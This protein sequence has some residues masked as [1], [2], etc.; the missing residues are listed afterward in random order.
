MSSPS[1]QAPFFR[2][3]L[4]VANRLAKVF[5]PPGFEELANGPGLNSPKDKLDAL[6]SKLLPRQVVLRAWS[7][8]ILERYTAADES[9]ELILKDALAWLPRAYESHCLQDPEDLFARICVFGAVRRLW[10]STTILDESSGLMGVLSPVVKLHHFPDHLLT[11]PVDLM[12]WI[13]SL[14]ATLVRL[15]PK[16]VVHAVLSLPFTKPDWDDE[17]QLLESMM[18]ARIRTDTFHGLHM[19]A[20]L[21][22]MA[23]RS[24]DSESNSAYEEKLTWMLRVMHDGLNSSYTLPSSVIAMLQQLIGDIESLENANLSSHCA[25]MAPF[26]TNKAAKTGPP[27]AIFPDVVPPFIASFLTD[28]TKDRV[29]FSNAQE[30]KFVNNIVEQ[31]MVLASLE[32]IWVQLDSDTDRLV[33]PTQITVQEQAL[34]ET[35]ISCAPGV[36]DLSYNCI[37]WSGIERDAN[38]ATATYAPALTLFFPLIQRFSLG[39]V[40]D[41]T[42]LP[43]ASHTLHTIG[44]ARREE[45]MM[46]KAFY[47]NICTAEQT[48]R[49]Y[50]F[51]EHEI[52][53]VVEM[54]TNATGLTPFKE[55]QFVKY[56]VAKRLQITRHRILE[57]LVGNLDHPWIDHSAELIRVLRKL[58]QEREPQT[59]FDVERLYHSCR[60][61]V[62]VTKETLHHL[63]LIWHNSQ[64]EGVR[65]KVLALVDRL[66]DRSIMREGDPNFTTLYR[67]LRHLE[68][69]VSPYK[70]AESLK[71]ILVLLQRAKAIQLDPLTPQTQVQASFD[72]LG[73]YTRFCS[74][75]A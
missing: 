1:P 12:P 50:P 58:T 52:Y 65:M 73:E 39:R 21:L 42:S 45:T 22:T 19:H 31:D 25:Q 8:L 26:I 40:V 56:T 62:E 3:L 63:R 14:D 64:S 18:S 53:R 15:A 67:W 32:G 44:T 60:Q 34:D 29:N 74:Y 35:L 36:F 75:Y 37:T 72:H 23:L 2:E 57:H 66:L 10:K 55:A 13:H 48:F 4:A 28:T 43:H 49:F 70:S 46:I 69:T 51:Y 6:M 7:K 20:Q 71:I 41:A 59:L 61:E 68:E 33:M 27:M 30:L 24:P 38:P 54:V 11:L 17:R 47:L 9:S 16:E 5:G